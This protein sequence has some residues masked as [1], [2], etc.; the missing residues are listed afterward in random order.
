LTGLSQ[1]Y[2]LAQN[3]RVDSAEFTDALLGD[4]GLRT[5]RLDARITGPIADFK[6]RRP[7]SNDPS[8]AGRGGG[9]RSTG[10]LLDEYFRETLNTRIDRSYRTL[11]LDLNSKWNF[12]QHDAPRFY[13]TV[14]P[15]LEQAMKN[16]ADLRIFIGGG[17]FDL[18]TP[19]M[20]GRYS[21]S[22]MDVRQDRITFAAYDGGH[23]VF[24]HE[25][26][27]VR[28]SDDI[29]A[30]ISPALRPAAAMRTK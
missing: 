30:F 28:L 10:E 21:M 22:Q 24:D 17:V 29:R 20:A 23:T 9:G 16:D 26:S 8:M 25:E 13:L 15:M 7:P 14:V 6:D 5:G 11:N 27:R 19:V 4:K 1:E 2:L 12:E 18:G 3:L